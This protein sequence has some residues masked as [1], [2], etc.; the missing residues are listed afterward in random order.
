[1][2]RAREEA[3]AAFKQRIGYRFR[4][5][6]LLERALTHASGTRKRGVGN[7]ERLEFLGD[8]VLG[9][10][11]AHI[12]YER[13]DTV[14][15]GELS[16]M[17]SS[18]VRRDVCL[19]V[20]QALDIA[21][22][23]KLAGRGKKRTVVTDNILG[24]ACEAV[25]GAIYLDGGMDAAAQFIKT[26]WKELLDKAPEARKDAKTVAQEWAARR[27]MPMPAYEIINQ[28]GPDHAPEFTVR[29]DVQGKASTE[30]T[31]GTR[32][33]AEQNAAAAF[34]KREKIWK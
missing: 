14:P 28:S 22:A 17:L 20:A 30:G 10:A 6:D 31:A 24:D 16:R 1:M 29:L 32:R 33:L 19:S 25:I 9:L 12:L 18:L 27:A 2:T 34:L 8:R 26:H 21:P 7:N 13:H 3:V 4:N 15:E 11:I 23:L 5:E